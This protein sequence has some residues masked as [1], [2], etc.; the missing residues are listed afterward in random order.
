MQKATPCCNVLLLWEIISWA[1][2][3]WNIHD[4]IVVKWK[5][6]PFYWPFVREIH[7][8]PVNS[9]HKGQWRGTLMFSLIC[10]WINR[11]VNNGEAG[12]LRCHHAHY[13]ITVMH[14]L[15]TCSSWI[16]STDVCFELSW[17]LSSMLIHPL[18]YGFVCCVSS[19][20]NCIRFNFHLLC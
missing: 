2:T 13:D 9:L 19:D 3:Q 10:V 17:I 5:H 16:Y 15:S 6:I 14:H 7:R 12:D 8:S 4:D 1:Q 11:W 18:H 20:N